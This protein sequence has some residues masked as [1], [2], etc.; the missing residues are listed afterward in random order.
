MLY[1]QSLLTRRLTLRDDPTTIAN[2]LTLHTCE[3]EETQVRQL[4]ELVVIG[5]VASTEQHPDA[6]KLTVCQVDC[7]THGYFQI[8][9]GADNVWSDMFVPVALPGAHLP[10]IDITIGSRKLRGMESNGMICAKEELGIYEE[11]ESDGIRILTKDLNDITDTDRGINLSTKYPRLNNVIRDVENK[12]ITH[13]PDLMG[14]AGIARELYAIYQQIDP[15]TLKNHN[16]TQWSDY[17]KQSIDYLVHQEPTTTHLHTIQKQTELCRAY[18]AIHLTNVVVQPSTFHTRLQLIDLGLTPR[19]N[20]VDFSN[21][22]MYQTGQPIHCFDGDQIDGAIIVRQA[23]NGEEFIDL[24]DTKHTLT[25]EDIVIADDTKILALA[26][27]IGWQS[28]AVTGQTANIV[29][30]L[31]NFDPIAI[32]KTAIRHRLRTDASAR[33]EKNINP[34]MTQSMII[35]LRDMMHYLQPD[36]G[37]VNRWGATSAVILPI[38]Q[39][40]VPRSLNELHRII[41]A[42]DQ[43][44]MD[45]ALHDLGFRYEEDQLIVPR[46]RSPRDIILP[47]DVAEE[48]VRIVGYDT[49]TPQAIPSTLSQTPPAA[50]PTLQRHIEDILTQRYHADSAETYPRASDE[51]YEFFG[52]DATQLPTLQNPLQPEQS[53]L[54]HSLLYDLLGLIVKNH[55]FYD[56]LRPYTIGS[57]RA[58]ESRSYAD[59]WWSTANLTDQTHESRQVGGLVYDALSTNG[60]TSNILTAKHIVQDIVN[61]KVSF[62]PTTSEHF[63]PRQQAHVTVNDQVIGFVGRL[64][65][66]ILDTLK[67]PSD[68]DLVYYTLDIASLENLSSRLQLTASS[69]YTLQDHILIRDLSFVVDRSESFAA[70]IDAIR[71]VEYITDIITFDVYQGEHLPSDKKSIA[72]QLSIYHPDNSLASD[73]INEILDQA[74]TAGQSTGAV[75]RKDFS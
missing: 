12:T 57:V 56:S 4:S 41:G 58:G 19:N 60:L 75:L 2:H 51:M 48:V 7:G 16:L 36:L 31:A 50:Q 32:R 62:V 14:H 66:L 55:K 74:I 71:Q 30:E 34:L 52:I 11:Q 18:Y 21:L 39:V 54:S 47:A 67:L 64:H 1:S 29:I 17:A 38:N 63:H 13:R 53:H 28:S 61:Q 20:W 10:A 70:L 22:F 23:V 6:D 49:L 46:R 68:A 69:Y 35:T 42:I 8:C 27:V 3:I 72:L 73:Q 40:H 37:T 24:M 15:S 65:P 44:H 59:T 9:C 26:G 5:Y 33:F 25:A 45:Q 43:I